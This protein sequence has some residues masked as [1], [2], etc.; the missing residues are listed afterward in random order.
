MPFY[1]LFDETLDINSTEN[2]ELSVQ[3]WAEGLSFCILDTLRNKVVLL[4]SFEPDENRYFDTARIEDL[5]RKDDFLTKRYKKSNIV[6]PSLKSTLVPSPLFE[7]GREEVYFDFNQTIDDGSIILSNKIPDP[8]SWLIFSIPRPL[9]EL[10][11]SFYPGVALNHQ[12]KP[13]LSFF[14]RNRKNGSGRNIHIHVEREF[15]NITVFDNINLNLCNTFQYKT[16]SDILYFVLNIFTRLNISRDETLWLSGL[17]RKNRDLIPSLSGYIRN[18]S[19]A[20]P[21]GNYNFSYVFN[22]SDLYR[23]LNLFTIMSCE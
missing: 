8:D 11:N 14:N 4:R 18:I 22:D 16:S 2:Y 23:F 15:F 12:L 13:L 21:S 1:E 7:S 6:T 19:F 5:I 10:L 3:A 20:W 9:K 17:V